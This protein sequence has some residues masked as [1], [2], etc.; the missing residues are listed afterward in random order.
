MALLGHTSS[1]DRSLNVD[2]LARAVL[3]TTHGTMQKE[4]AREIAIRVLNFFG[5]NSEIIDNILEPDDRDVFYMLEEEDLLKPD[6]EETTLYDGREWRIHYWRFNK[7]RIFAIVDGRIKILDLLK[8]KVVK[9]PGLYRSLTDH[10]MGGCTSSI[11]RYAYADPFTPKVAKP[12]DENANG[13]ANSGKNALKK[14][15][16]KKG[17]KNENPADLREKATQ[18]LLTLG[19]RSEMADVLSALMRLGV[20]KTIPDKYNANEMTYKLTAEYFS[21][22]DCVSTDFVN[23]A[24]PTINNEYIDELWHSLDASN[25]EITKADVTQLLTK[26]VLPLTKAARAEQ[27]LDLLKTEISDLESRISKDVQ[28]LKN[29]PGASSKNLDIVFNYAGKIRILRGE[30]GKYIDAII[31]QRLEDWKKFESYVGQAQQNNLFSLEQELQKGLHNSNLNYAFTD[32]DLQ[33]KKASLK[34]I[35]DKG[36]CVLITYDTFMSEF[37][38][39]SRCYNDAIELGKN[40]LQTVQVI[41]NE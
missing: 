23:H 18:E 2:D 34:N 21:F 4:D 36:R 1:T 12:V 17:L 19:M 16:L 30:L 33:G 14:K 25:F 40:I 24:N 41:E 10:I 9:N 39:V 15:G 29:V 11:L 22:F 31:E 6:R 8:G 35:Y 5:Y 38:K 26:G 20:V 28:I 3:I 13:A 7:N 27:T 32:V 37:A